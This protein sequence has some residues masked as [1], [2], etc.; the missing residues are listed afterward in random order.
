MTFF[1]FL[2]NAD[3]FRLMNLSVLKDFYGGTSAADV[4]A[5][6]KDLIAILAVYL[7]RGSEPF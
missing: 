5:V 3:S 2:G 1:A 6:L 7:R 4:A